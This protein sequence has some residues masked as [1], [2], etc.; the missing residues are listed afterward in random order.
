MSLTVIPEPAPLTTNEHGVVLVTGTRVPI[1]TIV[2]E[3]NQG[4]SPEE[5]VLSYPSLDLKDVYGVI[6]YYLGH[7]HEVDTYIQEQD[8]QARD[9]RE[10]YG[11][12]DF[13]RSLRQ[14]LIARS[15]AG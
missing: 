14:E 6:A 12:D 8:R 5:I 1:E 9:A 7:K 11:V 2:D 15:K 10:Q 13:S 4:A 3:F